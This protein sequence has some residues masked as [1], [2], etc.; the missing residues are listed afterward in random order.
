[1]SV[2]RLADLAEPG[3]YVMGDHTAVVQATG[4]CIAPTHVIK[5]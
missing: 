1:M 5:K 2:S 4:G 3:A